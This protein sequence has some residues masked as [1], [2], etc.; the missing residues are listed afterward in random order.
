[1]RCIW[2]GGG[3][4]IDL[5]GGGGGGFEKEEMDFKSGVI[6]ERN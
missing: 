4:G 3:H 1:M 6:F 2:E 5:K